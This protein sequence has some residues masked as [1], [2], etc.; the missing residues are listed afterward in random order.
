MANAKKEPG[1]A[2]SLRKP[3]QKDHSPENPKFLSKGFPLLWFAILAFML[4]GQSINFTYTYLDD[5]A[6]ILGNMNNLQSAS[7]LSKAFGEDV[8]HTP[9]GQGF[10]YR[11]ILTLSFMADAIAGK[12]SFS[13]FHF[14]NILYHILATFLLFLFLTEAGYERTKSFL[15]SL[16]FLVHPMVTQ[17]VAW[18]PGRNDSLLAIFILGSFLFWLKY[19]KSNGSKYMILHLLFYLLA[20]L[21]KENAIVLPLLIVLYST[22]I[23]RTPPKRYII[24]GSGW[25]I[26]TLVWI[27]IRYQALGGQNGVSASAQIL[28]V[29]KNLPALLPFLGKTLFPF[30]LSVYPVLADMKVSGILGVVTIAVLVFLV[31]ITKPKSWLF[32][33]FGILWF[34][35]FLVPSFVSINDLAP[36]FSEHRSYLS[37]VGIIL[38]VLEC[39]PVKKADFSR[40][41]PVSMVVILCLL[42]SVLT[43]LHTR[44][45]KDQF[46][47]WQ[48]AVDTSPSNSFNY[49]N[50]GA[51]YFLSDNLEKAEPLFLK[52]LEVN[53]AEPMANGNAGLICMRTERPAEAEKYYLEEIRINPKY[54]NV[55]YNLG[56]LYYNHSRFDEGILNWEKTLTIN[57]YYADAYKALLFAYDKLQRKADYERIRLKAMENGIQQ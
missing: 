24:A 49:N 45:F 35:A 5:H 17:V 54:D 29:I 8:F 25:I 13:L 51:M 22:T 27:T 56:L 55:Y 48:N 3:K 43:F 32:Y 30:D 34:L 57:P 19:L 23:L 38:I 7:Y 12:G 39:N 21:T 40:K 20:L 46:L 33:I 44:Y 14:S 36:K 31:A 6:L 47:F 42:Y 28:S 26:L 11:P 16:I 1:S 53:P 50:L 4:F 9:S 52:A 15:F 37:L 2:G 10:Y 18:I 41:L